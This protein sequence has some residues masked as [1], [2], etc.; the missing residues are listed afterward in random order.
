MRAWATVVYM[1]MS[2]TRAV[3]RHETPEEAIAARPT[4]KQ[5]WRDNVIITAKSNIGYLSVAALDGLMRQFDDKRLGVK[6]ERKEVIVK[7]HLSYFDPAHHDDETGKLTQPYEN[8][9]EEDMIVTDETPVPNGDITDAN[10]ETQQ[11][12]R[13]ES[14]AAAEDELKEVVKKVTRKR[15]G[16][17]SIDESI[18]AGATASTEDTTVKTAAKKKTKTKGKAKAVGAKT[19]A[20]K[21][22]RL[23]AVPGTGKKGFPYPAPAADSVAGKVL[24]YLGEQIKAKDIAIDEKAEKAELFERAAKKFERKVITIRT[25]ASDHRDKLKWRAPSKKKD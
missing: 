9:E 10:A 5:A 20:A 24:A 2:E 12:Q 3:A 8:Q 22:T 7:Q 15:R 21:K 4:L 17:P 1:N 14:G 18:A 16:V 19:A 25:Y 23:K 13:E 11:Q 6:K